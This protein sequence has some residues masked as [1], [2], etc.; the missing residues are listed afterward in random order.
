[1]TCATDLTVHAI[2]HLLSDDLWTIDHIT[3]GSACPG[4][5]VLT[6][7]RSITN[8]S[9]QTILARRDSWRTVYR[10]KVVRNTAVFTPWRYLYVHSPDCYP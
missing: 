3:E 4:A 5:T 2:R 7:K 6:P 9:L 1:M 8:Q 10:L